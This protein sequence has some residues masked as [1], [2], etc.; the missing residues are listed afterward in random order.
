[1][2][3][4]SL[5]QIRNDP[6]VINSFEYSN[7]IDSN[8]PIKTGKLNEKREQEIKNLEEVLKKDK[9]KLDELLEESI[10]SLENENFK[11]KQE[12]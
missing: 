9:D 1:M 7:Y 3:K 12:V 5:E 11:K 8:L 6:I 10:N 4:T 2:V